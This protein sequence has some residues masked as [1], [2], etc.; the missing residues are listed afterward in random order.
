MIIMWKI[1]YI[2]GVKWLENRHKTIKNGLFLSIIMIFY[3][4]T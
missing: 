3:E 4:N 1:N 2:C